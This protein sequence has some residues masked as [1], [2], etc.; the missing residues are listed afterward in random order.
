ML[1]QS[2]YVQVPSIRLSE[3][4]AR[5]WVCI[6]D[7]KIMHPT[8]R[9]RRFF[10]PSAEE[11]ALQKQSNVCTWWS[12][13]KSGYGW[14]EEFSGRELASAVNRC[15][16]FK[17]GLCVDV[18][19]WRQGLICPGKNA[20]LLQRWRKTGFRRNCCLLRINY[21]LTVYDP[22]RSPLSRGWWCEPDQTGFITALWSEAK[23]TLG[24]QQI[25]GP[26]FHDN[27]WFSGG[28][29]QTLT[30]AQEQHR[31][32]CRASLWVRQHHMFP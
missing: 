32:C 14:F 21:S 5:W 25:T 13:M 20:P 22:A 6:L 3:G 1:F 2:I 16:M 8:A 17:R 11:G 27:S 18:S 24:P 23:T 30:D 26:Y 9:R 4:S 12:L 31:A 19:D 15:Q 29:S 7:K 10:A 28:I